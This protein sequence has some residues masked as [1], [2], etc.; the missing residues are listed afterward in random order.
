[1]E[2][3]LLRR[4]VIG[5]YVPNDDREGEGMARFTIALERVYAAHSSNVLTRSCP[6]TFSLTSKSLIGSACIHLRSHAVVM[7]WNATSVGSHVLGGLIN[8]IVDREPTE[9]MT[10]IF[11]VDCGGR[12]G[13]R[14]V[15]V[16][17][18][19]V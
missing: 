12:K 5:Q 8:K 2:G 7:A 18:S 14:R 1:M 9:F 11:L 3:R 16:L 17:P 4:K 19:H 10:K 13:I 15:D 6:G